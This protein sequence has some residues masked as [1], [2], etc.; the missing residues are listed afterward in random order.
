LVF[1]SRINPIL[2][3]T[4]ALSVSAP[5]ADVQSWNGVDFGVFSNKRV[6][7][8]G[9]ASIRFRD[10][11]H[12][13]YDSY[14]GS[15]G[16]VALN[17]R[18]AI[19]AG[20]LYRQVNPDR[21]SFRH[22]HRLIAIPSVL[23]LPNKTRLEA[24]I[25]YERLKPIDHAPTFNRYRPRLVLERLRTGVSPFLST[26]G[27]FFKEQFHR[28]RNMTGIRWRSEQGSMIEVGYQF[29]IMRSGSA[30]IPRH[31]IRTTFVLGDIRHLHHAD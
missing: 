5:A 16:R 12:A 11:L 31:A 15:L 26:E 9:T 24:A 10:H 19:T 23:L 14:L 1:R 18:W 13:A 2:L 21:T 27:L 28:S 30:W 25:Q 8:W 4:L 17:P 3:F 20:Y 6:R 22:E 29:E 7:V